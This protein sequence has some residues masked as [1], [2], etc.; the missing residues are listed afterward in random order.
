MFQ[1]KMSLSRFTFWVTGKNTLLPAF[2]LNA[3]IK[4]GLNVWVSDLRL[5]KVN[6]EYKIEEEDKNSKFHW[7]GLSLPL[8][9]SCHLALEI[10]R[11]AEMHGRAPIFWVEASKGESREQESTREVVEKEDFMRTTH[12][13]IYQLWD[14]KICTWMNL[15]WI[16]IYKTLTSE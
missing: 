7:T 9:F 15:I 1:F 11:A 10:G 6:S 16:I 14:S 4:P 2:H 12:E 13:V 5:W 3:A 8:I